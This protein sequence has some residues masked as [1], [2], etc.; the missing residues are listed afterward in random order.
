MTD[1]ETAGAFVRMEARLRCCQQPPPIQT[2]RHHFI[3]RLPAPSLLHVCC[4]LVLTAGPDCSSPPLSAGCVFFSCAA[5]RGRRSSSAPEAAHKTSTFFSIDTT[6]LPIL[7]TLQNQ[8]EASIRLT[9]KH[10]A[11]KC[12]FSG[13]SGRVVTVQPS[14][15]PTPP[16][17][18]ATPRRAALARSSSLK[19][20][21]YVA[22]HK[23]TFFR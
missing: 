8:S 11:P 20:N 14:R 10:P 5:E 9:V 4:I 7:L 2:R 23:Q 19:A 17:L 1:E 3:S 18:A 22:P 16:R 15:V 12:G 13:G 6:A 21:P